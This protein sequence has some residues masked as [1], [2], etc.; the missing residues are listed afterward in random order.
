MRVI[1]GMVPPGGWHYPVDGITLRADG[2]QELCDLLYA[3][4]LRQGMVDRDVE[5]DVDQYFCSKWPNF[6]NKESSDYGLPSV[7]STLDLFT[8][9]SRALARFMAAQP[10]GGYALVQQIEATARAATCASCQFNLKWTKSCG[11]CSSSAQTISLQLRKHRN[12][13]SDPSLRGCA[14]MGVDLLSAVHLPEEA[15]PACQP[16]PESCWRKA[17]DAPAA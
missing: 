11:R 4:Y 6:C 17:P 7:P 15:L 13:P 14:L 10:S 12:T 5:R 3:H 1:R 9:V 16:A 8:R 2:H